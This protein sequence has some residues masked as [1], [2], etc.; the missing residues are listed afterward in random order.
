MQIVGVGVPVGAAWVFS[1]IVQGRP[2]LVVYER[3]GKALT[4]RWMVG[5]AGRVW[6]ETLTPMPADHPPP[7]EKPPTKPSGPVRQL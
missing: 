3:D 2:G 1:Y 7:S 4:G 5:G 6:R